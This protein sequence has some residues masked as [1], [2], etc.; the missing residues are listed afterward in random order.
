MPNKVGDHKTRS[1]EAHYHFAMVD[2]DQTPKNLNS[3]ISKRMQLDS[4]SVNFLKGKEHEK[5]LLSARYYISGN[6]RRF[7]PSQCREPQAIYLSHDQKFG[8]LANKNQRT[9][10]RDVN[11]IGIGLCH[12]CVVMCAADG[13]GEIETPC[14]PIR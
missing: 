7:D 2:S 9:M 3:C 14:H 13:C 4:V 1:H 6:S 12:A 11:Y 10:Q 5:P 8:H